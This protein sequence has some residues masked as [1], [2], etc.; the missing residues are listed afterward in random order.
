MNNIDDKIKEIT[1]EF[2][3]QPNTSKTRTQLVDNLLNNIP[4][5]TEVKTSSLWN[6]MSL[7]SK[8]FWC[9]ANKLFPFIGQTVR[10]YRNIA[11]KYAS[12]DVVIEDLPDWAVDVPKS[13][14]KVDM[15]LQYIRPAETIKIDLS[16]PKNLI[17]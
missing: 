10:K 13:V 16:I 11:R 8:V 14:I 15:R 12:E 4:N 9:V 2:I 1:R 7:K 3:G 6:R 17:K 5:T